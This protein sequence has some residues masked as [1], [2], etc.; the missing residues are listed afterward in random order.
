[1]STIAFELQ[2]L[3]QQTFGGRPHVG[4]IPATPADAPFVIPAK[5]DNTIYTV[6][7]GAPLTANDLFGVE[8]WLPVWFYNLPQ[9]LGDA[10][11]RLFLPY[12]VV[13]ITGSSSFVRTPLAE[14]QGTVK[15][16][17][18]V[19][20]YKINIKGFFI[21]K[22]SRDLPV[23]DLIR[24]KKLH[25]LGRAF[26]I[27]NALTDIFLSKPASPEDI[28]DQQQ[29]VLTGFELPEVEGGRKARP[30]SLTLESDNIFTLEVE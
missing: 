14:R 10:N 11:G 21:D 8:V 20:D 5:T 1:M 28:Y 18:S 29:V 22:A 26:S 16:L 12:S 7:G 24:L 23:A 17:Y 2:Q 27:W 9:G 30:Y 13:R 25:E 19:D 3:Y 4:K 6:S 15:E